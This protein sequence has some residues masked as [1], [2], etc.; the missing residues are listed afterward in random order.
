M[1]T[2]VFACKDTS[3]LSRNSAR[4]N[5]FPAGDGGY[6]SASAGK[7]KRRDEAMNCTTWSIFVAVMAAAGGQPGSELLER[8]GPEVQATP[9]AAPADVTLFRGGQERTG[10][11]AGRIAIEH[12][13]LLSL[14]RTDGD[15]GE[16]LLADGVIYVGDRSET[17][18]AIR[19]ADG[20]V[21]WRAPGIGFV[22]C[23]PARKG[24]AI[25]VTSQFGLKA[26]SRADG[27]VLWNMG[28]D[29][30]ATES[31]PLIVSDRIIVGDTAGTIT[32]VSFD[33][34]VIWK[35]SVTAD[36]RDRSKPDEPDGADEV[37][38][39]TAA[40]DGSIVY[41]PVFDMKRIFAIDLKAGRRRW[42][43]ETK[44]WIYGVPALSNDKLFF[45]SQDNHLYCLDKARKKTLWSFP[46]KSR[47][48]AGVAYQGGSAYCAACDGG[49]YRVDAETGKEIWSY[50][51]PSSDASPAIYSA[52]VCTENAVYFGSFDGFVYCLNIDNGH[53][54]WRFC[55][56]EGA[57]IT[58]SP[59]TDGH[60]IA[61]SIRKSSRAGTGENGIV[62]IGDKPRQPG[63]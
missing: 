5:R 47:I 41:Q 34:K 7:Q 49:V 10:S 15:P 28:L 14:I 11:I 55:P 24:D 45:G 40:S 2:E 16:A 39:R 31:S 38:P 48:E 33:G 26:L 56:V 29:G 51:T 61:L 30:V 19:I 17:I 23:A 6:W 42:A 12:P 36:D 62:I 4:L 59:Q 52:P 44:G 27:K 35:Y 3:F 46:T 58:G 25:Y 53:L 63:N 43:F 21:L 32:A 8:T 57:E 50:K 22:Y 60:R 18:H 9:P 1:G 54:K 37:R 13:E 20:K